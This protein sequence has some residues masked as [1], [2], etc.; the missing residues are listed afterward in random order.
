MLQKDPA[1]KELICLMGEISLASGK[2]DEAENSFLRVL[3]LEPNHTLALVHISL[4]YEQKGDQTKSVLYK[5]RLK[6]VS[7]R[8]R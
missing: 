5:E 7:E 8:S 6:R 1:N 3:Y 2:V 4:L